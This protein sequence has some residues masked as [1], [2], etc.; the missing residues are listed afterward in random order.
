MIQMSLFCILLWRLVYCSFWSGKGL[1]WPCVRGE[2]WEAI[3]CWQA[4]PL[5]FLARFDLRGVVLWHIA[6]ISEDRNPG[7]VKD[8]GD[9]KSQ[10]RMTWKLSCCAV[11]SPWTVSDV[12]IRTRATSEWS[13]LNGGRRGVSVLACAAE[14]VGGVRWR[15]GRWQ[16]T[17]DED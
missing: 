4:F 1:P 6:A 17:R 14:R 8:H 3:S 15:R 10:N 5:V 12:F 9:S 7:R 11:K 2:R 16:G 13:I